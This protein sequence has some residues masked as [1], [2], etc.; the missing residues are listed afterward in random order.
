MVVSGV[1]VAA[2]WLVVRGVPGWVGGVGS[3]GGLATNPGRTNTHTSIHIFR[4]NSNNNNDDNTGESVA[5]ENVHKPCTPSK[6]TASTTNNVLEIH[7]KSCAAAAA[8][9]AFKG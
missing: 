4:T 6:T 3:G 8:G 5:P 7:S 1:A 9:A 2:G